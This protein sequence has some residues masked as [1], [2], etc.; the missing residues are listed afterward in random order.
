MKKKKWN[1]GGEKHGRR[2]ERYDYKNYHWYI[3]WC[4]ARNAESKKENA[5]A[6]YEELHFQYISHKAALTT[7]GVNLNEI[8]LIKE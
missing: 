2:D 7:L 1:E 8:D 6:T 4:T 3:Y 5:A